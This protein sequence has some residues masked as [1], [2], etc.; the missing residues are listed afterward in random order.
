MEHFIIY[1]AKAS[2]L[3]ALFFAAYYIFLRKETFFTANRRYLILG[4]L[5]AI[6]MPALVYKKIVWVEPTL[7]QAVA[8]D[9]RE[10][11]L[12]QL[13]AM[14]SKPVA[15]LALQEPEIV[16][17]WFDVAAGVY[18]A[19]MVFFLIRFIIE[20][21]SLR[22]L[23]KGQSIINDGKFLLVDTPKVQSPFS[24]FNY[25]V[26]NSAVLQPHELENILVHEK[27]HSS[28]RHSLDMVLSQLFCIAFWFNPLAWAYRKSI[29]QNLEF[30][31]DAE[32]TKLVSDKQ[33]Y[34]KTLLK[35][36]LQ[37]EYIAITNHFYQSLIKKRIVMLNKKESKKRNSWKY[38]IV[39]PALAA[40]M[41]AF[42]VKV[43]AQE[44]EAP[45][46]N[47]V[48]SNKFKMV[49]EVTK[50]S[51]DEELQAEKKLFKQE[52]DADVDFQNIKRNPKNE[53]TAIKVTVKDKTQSQVYEV[54]GTKPIASFTV[55]VE[56]DD[57]GRKNISFGTVNK[58][59]LLRSSNVMVYN[60]TDS[61]TVYTGNKMI[62]KGNGSIIAMPAPPATPAVPSRNGIP[63]PSVPPTPPG[64]WTFNSLKIGNEDM[65][66][67]INGVQQKKG[68]PIR[69]ALTE[70]ISEMKILKNKEAKKKYGK[71][72]KDGAVEITTVS[73]GM[74]FGIDATDR[75]MYMHK[76][77]DNMR[78]NIDDYVRGFTD[79]I[80]KPFTFDF[81][82]SLDFS[83]EDMA[84]IHID[85]AEAH[86]GIEEALKQ[87]KIEFDGNRLTDDELKE[88][89]EELLK[90]KREIMESKRELM[91]TRREMMKQR[92]DALKQK[93]EEKKAKETKYKKA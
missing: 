42:Q 25:I 21:I 39:L 71:E 5:T 58:D 29:S 15:N 54:A 44:K 55:E 45:E 6:I 66:V 81:S 51:K 17:N 79:G 50:D 92:K 27:V 24:F 86:R 62:I 72:A 56:K 78:F 12:D 28:Q 59:R 2:G 68:E 61:D 9:Y 14:Q 74:A 77:L 37:P 85:M 88:I 63:T 47:A 64:H 26:Y 60:D 91:E 93:V 11:S 1:M 10:I 34:Q 80:D 3:T 13:M 52:F 70:E 31:A 22:R 41:L 82:K 75:M 46:T 53:I 48:T 90:A 87:A 40:F 83:D 73:K 18:F 69:L 19:G 32:A 67:V 30:I 33:T 35:I 76:G 36:T 20:V 84:K 4:L 16:I 43:V 89:R 57:T 49:L 8:A 65:L 7:V 38:A 23:L